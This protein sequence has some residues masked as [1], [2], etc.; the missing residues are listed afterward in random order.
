M[1]SW[2]LPSVHCSPEKCSPIQWID[3]YSFNLKKQASFRRS[4]NYCFIWWGRWSSFPFPVT[5]LMCHLWVFFPPH[6]RL[7]QHVPFR[8]SKLTHYLQGFFC[9]RGNVS[10]IVNISQCASLYDETLNVLKLSA[11]AQ[12]VCLH[13]YFVLLS[14]SLNVFLKWPKSN[15]LI[16]E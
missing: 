11:V 15:S 14:H 3:F 10:M 1:L 13:F 9:A 7:L 8:E 5:S 16:C 2:L 12:K 6:S 4:L